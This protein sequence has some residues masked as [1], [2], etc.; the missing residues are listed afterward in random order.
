MPTEREYP[1]KKD[2]RFRYVNVFRDQ[3]ILVGQDLDHPRHRGPEVGAD[4]PGEEALSAKSWQQDRL[5][6]KC[7]RAVEGAAPVCQDCGAKMLPFAGTWYCPLSQLTPAGV[8]GSPQSLHTTPSNCDVGLHISS[9]T[10]GTNPH[11]RSERVERGG[12]AP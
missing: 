5:M 8:V 7:L 3:G 9:S 6:N 1:C 11:G 2:P 10:P 12:K 4:L